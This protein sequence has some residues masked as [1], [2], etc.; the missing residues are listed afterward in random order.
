MKNKINLLIVL[1]VMVFVIGCSCGNMGNMFSDEKQTGSSPS[2]DTLAD[3]TIE[4]VVDGETTGVPECDD[5]IKFFA[6]QTKSADDNWVTKGMRNLMISQFK[7]SLK[8][9]IEKNKDDKA[10]M[11]EQCKEVKKQF[12]AS[13]NEEKQKG[14]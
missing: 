13:L 11:A 2:N 5:V 3:K 7:K 4:T 10:K 14:K 12:E 9:S 1:A 8:E 6:D